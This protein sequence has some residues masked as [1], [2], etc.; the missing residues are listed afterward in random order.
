MNLIL[1]RTFSLTQ[2]EVRH[3]KQLFL[4]KKKLI[5]EKTFKYRNKNKKFGS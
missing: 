1:L 5:K 4:N 2:S 3:I